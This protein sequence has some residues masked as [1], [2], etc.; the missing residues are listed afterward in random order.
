MLLYIYI[1]V[2]TIYMN[3]FCPDLLSSHPLHPTCASEEDP[4][5]H[6]LADD[7]ADRPLCVWDVSSALY[8]D[9]LPPAD[10]SARPGQVSGSQAISEQ[11]RIV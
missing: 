7:P 8:E 2:I 1:N 3:H 4:L 6:G 5:L 9:G 11:N 10:D